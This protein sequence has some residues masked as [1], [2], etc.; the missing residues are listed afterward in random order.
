M[1]WY[2][3]FGIVFAIYAVDLIFLFLVALVATVAEALK[4]PVTSKV[5]RQ[6]RRCGGHAASK[7]KQQ[8]AL[9][10]GKNSV[11]KAEVAAK[12]ND[13]NIMVDTRQPLV[14]S[15]VRGALGGIH[16]YTAVA[17][18]P[19]SCTRVLFG[20]RELADVLWVSSSHER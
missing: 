4:P 11:S 12:D 19:V 2:I 3:A 5:T 8:A 17:S 15:L 10:A 14:R 16:H 7:Q 1:W 18:M 13:I 20:R 6:A 9:N